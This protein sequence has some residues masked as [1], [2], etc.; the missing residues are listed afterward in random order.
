MRSPKFTFFSMEYGIDDS[1]PIF[2]GG[3]GVLAGDMMKS[4]T[5]L[6]LD[7]SFFGLIYRRGYFRQELRN[8]WQVEHYDAFDPAEQMTQLPH[9]VQV[10]IE[11]R[12]V[13]VGAWC[14]MLKGR[15]GNTMPGYFLDTDLEGNSEADRRITG[16]LYGSDSDY[17]I[18]QELV[19]GVG[20]VK[21]L[22]ALGDNPD[23]YHI[24][25]GHGAFVMAEMLREGLSLD[26]I[27]KRV[28][29][30]TH[31]PVP[32]G[33][34]RFQ[35]DIVDRVVNGYFPQNI[36]SLIQS[37]AG[38]EELNMTHLA[39]N[40]S[41]Y[42]NAVSKLH[43]EVTKDMFSRDDIDF[44]TNG[45]HPYTWTSRAFQHLYDRNCP[46]WRNDASALAQ[47]ANIPT[48]ELIAAHQ[49]SKLCMMDYVSSKGETL[50]PNKLTIG[51]ARR[52]ATYKRGSLLFHDIERLA[53]IGEGKLQLVFAGKAHPQD[54]PGKRIIQA[55]H[56]AAARLRGTISVIFLDNY[57]MNTGKLITAGCDVWLNAPLVG[58]EASGTSGM[59]AAINGVPHCSTD[60]GWWAEANH[61][62]GWTFGDGRNNDDFDADSLYRVISEKMLPEFNDP[63]QWA[64]RMRLAIAD[65]AVF[66]NTERSM[67][68]YV[69]VY[70]RL[71][72]EQQ[73]PTEKLESVS[74]LRI[75][76]LFE[77][78][79]VRSAV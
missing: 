74:S 49:R 27:K 65:N 78:S 61:E 17:R 67:K 40:A 42:R 46:E 26:E 34:D 7:G 29:F 24:N 43:H 57:T 5:D 21:M 9:I 12:V 48:S 53:K 38:E 22:R 18:K 70:E 75:G 59:K 76:Q 73:V 51:F 69:A 16:Y 71:K 66:F 52:Y 35:K 13:N 64:Q 60:D 44:V 63:E 19:L 36:K 50:D 3:L 4:A 58:Y 41:G 8:G 31:T 45:V 1:L 79:L 11:D 30:T 25:E 77:E 62:A 54:D 55:I 47:V 14:Y 15:A 6:G 20:G 39:M 33:H 68:E 2:A 10:H 56:E 32:A 72:V 37:L 23:I 28:I